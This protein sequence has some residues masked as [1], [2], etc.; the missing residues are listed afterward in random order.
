VIVNV[1]LGLI[2]SAWVFAPHWQSLA[3]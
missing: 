2:L 1:I 3:H